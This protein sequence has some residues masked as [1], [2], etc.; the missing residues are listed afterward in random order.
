MS[1]ERMRKETVRSV[2]C[3]REL[4]LLCELL[5]EY[6][7][8]PVLLFKESTFPFRTAPKDYA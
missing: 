7:M 6:Q 8:V 5:D 2:E 4:L 3:L 1:R